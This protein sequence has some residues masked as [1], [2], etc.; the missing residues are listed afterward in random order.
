MPL[1][2]SPAADT[3]PAPGLN[4]TDT[5][6]L[7]ESGYARLARLDND[8]G[9]AIIDQHYLIKV[10]RELG[11]GPERTAA[12]LRAIDCFNDLIYNLWEKTEDKIG[13]GDG[14]RND[15]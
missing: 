9:L 7:P 8:L 1:K 12:L 5:S 6:C 4:V 2:L 13:Q 10:A 11:D 14:G 3:S 15:H